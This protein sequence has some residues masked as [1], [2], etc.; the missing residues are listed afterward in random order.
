MSQS[1]FNIK[2]C[3]SSIAHKQEWWR[4]LRQ[5]MALALVYQQSYRDQCQVTKAASQNDWTITNH[6]NK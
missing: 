1:C 4:E 3:T 5:Q 6:Q 2:M